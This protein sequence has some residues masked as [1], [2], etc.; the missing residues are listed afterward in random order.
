[1]DLVSSSNLQ[2]SSKK[3]R[4]LQHL[5]SFKVQVNIKD[6][7]GSPNIEPKN[8]GFF[9]D[10]QTLLYKENKNAFYIKT[11]N[12]KNII[13]KNYQRILNINYD[14]FNSKGH[15][16]KYT[17]NLETQC[18]DNENL[19][20]VFEG[21]KRYTSLEKYLKKHSSNITEENLIII[22]RQ[23][24]ESA[25]FL[26]NNNIYGCQ[27]Y[28]SSY[29]YDILTETIKLTDT[30][31]SKIFDSS[32][33]IY[34]H[35][36]QNGFKFNEYTPPEVFTKLGDSVSK[37]EVEKIQNASFD[38][39]QMGILFF[40]IA[41]NGESP[42]DNAK[43]ESLKECIIN[44]NINYTK[45][46]KYNSQIAQIIDKMLQK[47][48]EKRY[49]INQLLSLL[50]SEDNTIPLLNIQVPN[51]K[52]SVITMNMVQ[53][54]ENNPKME[55]DIIINEE[56]NKNDES[57]D[58]NNKDLLNGIKIQGNLVTD[59]NIL[60][61]QEIYPDGSV[62]PIFKNKYLNRFQS[63]VDQSLISD[64]AYK[65]N[66]LEKEYQKLDENKLAVYNIT[67]YINN[68]LKELNTIDND[69]IN[70]LI[71]KFN[72]L[73]LSK[74]ETN[75]L[76]EE[77]LKDKEE[78][79]QDKFKA[80][81]SNLLYEIKR[82][83][84]ELDQEKST[85]EKLKKKI[86]EQEKKNLDLKNEH[87]ERVEFYQKKIEVLEEVIFSIENKNIN[88][89]DLKNKNKLIYNALIS[90]IENFTELN[91]TLKKSLEENILKF[92][93]NK[94][95]WLEDIIKAKE[96]FRNEMSFYLKKSVNEP[97]IYNFYKTE[98]QE[99][100]NKTKENVE[101]L[102]KEIE[103]LR[104]V[105]KELNNSIIQ[106]TNYKIKTEK[107]LKEKDEEIEILKE[108]L[109]SQKDRLNKHYWV[110]N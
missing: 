85:N 15:I 73:M 47:D 22:F 39:W 11:I 44:K 59:N 96:D 103:E 36:L 78:F 29:I 90:S 42:Y 94:K 19:F 28:L 98:K 57:T 93:D 27:L 7:I 58:N 74:I 5:Q 69:N 52:E 1:M 38:I 50:Q 51:K 76:Y 104:N 72:N 84:I 12:K 62:L 26:H 107:E 66:L 10:V 110:Y 91:K 35:E 101:L 81:I 89:N 32:K 8:L 61:N 71:K 86:K 46:D 9:D 45:L 23:I 53:K 24:I 17:L 54:E 14:I 37:S 87:Q 4:D 108:E 40:K 77:M 67:N 97:K 25:N 64:L 13:D 109:N 70:Y 56:T 43:N 106:N 100:K 20:L 16:G 82:L 48:P 21:I 6:F 60:M 18:E 75:D 49:N 63:N 95:N 79:T 83:G 2:R 88:N 30:G 99:I 68:Y 31:F 102:K 3:V 34:D 55:K 41:V 65:L 92:K 80:L 105:N 33:N